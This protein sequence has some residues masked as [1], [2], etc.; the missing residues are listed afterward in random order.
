MM[1]NWRRNGGFDPED[2]ERLAVA[3]DGSFELWRTIGWSAVGRF[4][5]TLA[6]QTRDLLHAAVDAAADAGPYEGRVPHGA[7]TEIYDLGEQDGAEVYAVLGGSDDPG[8]GWQRLVDLVRDLVQGELLRSPSAAVVLGVA[9]GGHAVHLQHA[10]DEP[11]VLDLSAVQIQATRMDATERL[12]EAWSATLA[13]GTDAETAGP[14]WT[15]DLPLDHSLP[16]GDGA[17]VQLRVFFGL[18]DGITLRTAQ[19]GTTTALS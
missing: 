16:G 19:L 6:D 2:E 7:A 15:L 9:D 11:L 18:R 1:L 10:G 8:G 17:K 4:S 3:D 5:G 14:G 13:A 12:D